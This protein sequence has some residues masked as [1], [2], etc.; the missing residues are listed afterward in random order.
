MAYITWDESYSVNIPSI[1]E[2]HKKLI[3]LIN[4]YYEAIKQNY[5]ED[6]LIKL[7]NG[8]AEYTDYHFKYE[9]VLMGKFAY[10]ETAD[11]KLK[12]KDFID[13]VASVQQKIKDKKIVIPLEITNF[14]K[15]WLVE[16]IKKTDK[17]YSEFF[18]GNGVS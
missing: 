17:K 2:Q 9:E 15:S 14:L 7:L 16:H 1:D 13:K 6:K 3:L 10:A 11:H 8:L 4:E 5:S 18:I 12:H